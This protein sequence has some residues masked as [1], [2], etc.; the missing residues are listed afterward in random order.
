MNAEQLQR[1]D[2]AN[3]FGPPVHLQVLVSTPTITIY[4]CNST[5]KLIFNLLYHKA[6]FTAAT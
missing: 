1:L 6:N 5:Q 3:Q 2:Q 4:Y